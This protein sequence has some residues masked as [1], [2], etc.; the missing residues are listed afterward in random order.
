MINVPI[1]S[2][3]VDK[4][5]YRYNDIIGNN[6]VK[7]ISAWAKN[8]NIKVKFSFVFVYFMHEEDAVA[9]RL[10]FSK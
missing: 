2:R 6:L 4:E 7:D 1:R 8:I 9:Y 5:K 3:Y 10:K